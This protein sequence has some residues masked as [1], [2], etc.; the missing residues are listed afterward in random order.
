MSETRERFFVYGTLTDP[1]RLARVLDE[2]TVE[3]SAVLEG[4]HRVDGEYPTL[5]PGGQTSGQLIR[6]G[7]R[8]R[9]DRYEG[10]SQGLYICIEI[11]VATGGSAGVYVGDPAKLAAPDDW[12]GDGSFS[13]RLA[14]YLDENTVMIR[15]NGPVSE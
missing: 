15:R 14:A 1:E 6:T 12:P 9:L 10:V 5:A 3:G 13:A 7:E 11:P 4:L 2:W 8:D